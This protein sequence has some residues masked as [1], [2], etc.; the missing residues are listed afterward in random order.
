MKI[1]LKKMTFFDEFVGINMSLHIYTDGSCMPNPGPGGWGWV[2]YMDDEEEKYDFGG[3]INSTN[4]IME[5]KALYYALKYH[6]V[7]GQYHF[8]SDS[9]Y[10]V[11][12]FVKNVRGETLSA[13]KYT[14]WMRGWIDGGWKRP[15]K[16]VALWKSLDKL[17]QHHLKN[18]SQLKL[19]WVKAHN[20][21]PKNDRADQLANLGR[22]KY[23]DILYF[24]IKQSL[25]I[26]V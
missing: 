21:N 22:E 20:K 23:K 3:E 1:P 19:G 4:N 12:G 11:K 15:S 16:N 2:S 10:V 9:Q 7:G 14:G 13:G 6:P 25:D 18:G 8:H 24:R 17:I 26:W 5:L